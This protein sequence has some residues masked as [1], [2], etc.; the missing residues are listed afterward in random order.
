[1]AKRNCVGVIGL[2]RMGNPVAQRFIG[3]KMPLMVWDVSEERREPFEEAEGV[4]IATPREIGEA[5]AVVFFVVPSS[6]EIS[7]CFKGKD[8]LLKN[9]RKGLVV[10]DLTTSD[11]AKTKRLAK[12]A[13][14]AGL[15]YL[16]AGM[17]GGPGN[18]LQGKL[19]LIIGGDEKLLKRTRRYLEPFVDHTFHLGALGSGHTMKLIH[20]MVLHTMFLATCEGARLVERL[21]MRVEDMIDVFNAS[22]AYSYASRHRFPNNILSGTWNGQAR[23]YNLQKDVGLAVGIGRKRGADIQLA[24]HTL[25]FLRKAVERGMIEEDLTLL[26]RDFDQ[27]QKM[28]A[29]E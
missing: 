11:P 29:P 3:A 24:E 25:S 15:G 18:I 7:A 23:I 26:Y 20:N 21:G 19:T 22:A 8:G 4:T 5:C 9:P 2:G 10:Y 1:M 14:R 6:D 28:D 17:S 12:R 27:I 13:E 16:D